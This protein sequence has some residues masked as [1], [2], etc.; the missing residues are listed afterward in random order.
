MSS[1]S[2]HLGGEPEELNVSLGLS[3]PHPPDGRG[4]M[5][6][7]PCSKLEPLWAAFEE[8]TTGTR[9]LPDGAYH[10]EAFTLP[11][12]MGARAVQ[13]AAGF[14]RRLWMACLAYAAYPLRMQSALPAVRKIG[15]FPSQAALT[16]KPDE[17][18]AQKA[19]EIVQPLDDSLKESSKRNEGFTKALWVGQSTSGLVGLVTLVA[20]WARKLPSVRVGNLVSVLRVSET[21]RLML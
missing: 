7:V 3:W 1:F 6:E 17:L 12:L 10:G 2:W 18:R 14:L 5:T 4:A 16:E 21:L 20:V 13:A 9:R 8:S 19:G 15:E 11:R